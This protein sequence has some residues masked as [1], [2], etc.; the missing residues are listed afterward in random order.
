MVSC[1]VQM[2]IGDVSR[3]GDVNTSGMP[4]QDPVYVVNFIGA[5]S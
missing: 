1:G 2:P 4:V 3:A 5:R